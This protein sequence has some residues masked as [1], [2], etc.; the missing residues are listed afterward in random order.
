VY[1][2]SDGLVIMLTD[3]FSKT[4]TIISDLCNQS[5]ALLIEVLIHD[6]NLFQLFEGFRNYM[7]LGRGDFYTYVIHKLE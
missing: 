4:S 1:A 7:L 5:S 3:K 6:C 2:F